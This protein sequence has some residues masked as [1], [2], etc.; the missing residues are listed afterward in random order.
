[1]EIDFDHAAETITVDGVKISLELL[2]S[3]ANPDEKRFYRMAR[4]GDIVTVESFV[5]DS[6]T[7]ERRSEAN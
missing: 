2:R 6:P 5:M 1:M 3:F 7:F 4:H